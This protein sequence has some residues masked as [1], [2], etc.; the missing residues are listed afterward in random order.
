VE[1]FSLQPNARRNGLIAKNG[2]SLSRMIPENEALSYL[3]VR[4]FENR[5]RRRNRRRLVTTMRVPLTGLQPQPSS[6]FTPKR[7]QLTCSHDPD[8]SLQLD[9]LLRSDYLIWLHQE[10]EARRTLRLE[11]EKA[12]EINTM[13]A[14]ENDDPWEWLICCVC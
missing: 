10:L 3:E 2:E 9:F 11:Q 8:A 14:E 5:L 6:V 1:S 4:L 7:V 13:L 12:Y